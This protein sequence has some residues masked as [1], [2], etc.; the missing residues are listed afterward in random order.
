MAI[1]SQTDTHFH[2]RGAKLCGSAPRFIVSMSFQVGIT[3]RLALPQSL[4]PLHHG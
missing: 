4:P 1:Y 2:K 3:W